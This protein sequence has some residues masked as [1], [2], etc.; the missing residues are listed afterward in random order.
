M[1]AARWLEP[2]YTD[3]SVFEKDFP[4]IDIN[5]LQVYC[6]GC[7]NLVRLARKSPSG[8]IAGWCKTCNRA[9]AP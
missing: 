5:G 3:R 4:G 2:R 7:R 9:V 1:K 8:K 6:P